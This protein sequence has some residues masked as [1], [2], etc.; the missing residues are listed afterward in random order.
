MNIDEKALI[1]F[2]NNTIQSANNVLIAN[3]I[4]KVYKHGQEVGYEAGQKSMVDES[5]II[6]K[7]VSGTGL[8]NINDVSEIPHNVS[9]KLS[10]DTIT[11]FSNVGLDV[12]NSN[13][14]DKD[15]LL[16][17]F[18]SD[19]EGNLN[20][21]GNNDDLIRTIWI[22]LPKGTYTISFGVNVKIIRLVL[23]GEFSIPQ[24]NEINNVDNYVVN[25][26]G[27]IFGLSFRHYDNTNWNDDNLVRINCGS[28]SLPY[29]VYEK[30]T[31]TSENGEFNIRSTSPI[32]NFYCANENV[33]IFV[34]YHK[35]YGMQTE[36]D[37][38][39]DAYQ[40]NGTRTN[41]SYAFGGEGWKNKTFKPKY[42]I[43]VV[44]GKYAFSMSYIYMRGWENVDLDTS[45]MTDASFMFQTF[46][47]TIIPTIDISKVTSSYGTQYMF[48]TCQDLVTIEKLIV[49]ENTKYQTSMFTGTKKLENI[50][51]E[52]TI[53]NNNLD[54][55]PCTK[56]SKESIT[57]VINA[58]SS[59]TT[60]LKVTLSKTA[61]NT[62]F[63]INV[64]DV[65]TYPEGSEYYTLRHSKDNWT[66]SYI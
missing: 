25:T 26:N 56:L 34:N 18:L 21:S 36:Y 59:T 16:K 2:N 37:R 32:M 12:Y 14:F 60:G 22:E 13:L 4:S 46:Y 6:E 35:S 38:F 62:A 54:L 47:G 40:S 20:T 53:A 1:I 49:S 8:V 3:N 63:S 27:G 51:F 28:I 52:G 58:L 55:S 45:N 31:L 10:S 66:F 61:V 41:Y 19:V 24:G 29:E 17:G 9:I 57:S 5:K 30:K 33:N 65:T 64:D 50:I 44:N 23:N 15:N 48:G 11:D 43:T 42:P 39:W 7:T